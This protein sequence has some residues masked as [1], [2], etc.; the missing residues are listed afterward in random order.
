MKLK[1]NEI[2]KGKKIKQTRI[3]ISNSQPFKL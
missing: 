1:K 2:K 3:N